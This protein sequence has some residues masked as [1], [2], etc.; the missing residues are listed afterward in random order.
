M[1]VRFLT[2][3]Q[4]EKIAPL[5]LGRTDTVGVTAK[6]NRRDLLHDLIGGCRF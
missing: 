6:D 5:L 3:A 1:K 2:D 4:W